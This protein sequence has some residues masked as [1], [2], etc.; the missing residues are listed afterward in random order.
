MLWEFLCS[1]LNISDIVLPKPSQIIATLWQRFP[2]LWPHTIQTLYTT[3]V[4]FGFGI[5]IGISLGMLVGSSKSP[6]TWL[7]RC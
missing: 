6:M 1:A 7:I 2:Q 4:G 5:L 3:L